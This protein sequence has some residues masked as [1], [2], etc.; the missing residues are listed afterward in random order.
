MSDFD[1]SISTNPDFFIANE[2]LEPIDCKETT[3]Y[4]TFEYVAANGFS[5][6]TS[7]SASGIPAGATVTFLPENLSTSGLVT[8]TISNLEG[9][10]Q[11]DYPITIT[12]TP[13]VGS[14]KNRN[15]LFPFYNQ[16]C[17]SVANTDY[18]TSTT[19]VEFNTIN[20]SSLKPSGYSDYT[21]IS[22]DV[23]RGS[24]YNLTVNTNTDGNFGTNTTVWIDWNQDCDFDD[25]GETYN[26]GT[27]FN[28]LDGQ[29]SN[30][31]L[32]ITIP[33]DAVL[34]NTTM[35]VTTKFNDGTSPRSCENGFD[36]EVE[37]YTLTV[38]ASKAI[39]EFGFDNFVVF[40]NPNKGQFYIKLNSSLS[41]NIVVEILA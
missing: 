14:P 21:A 3:A 41:S 6:N 8:M 24:A 31:P 22:T 34:G 13:T 5:E 26:L 11:N 4:F 32:S 37:D 17:P 28:E 20:N 25:A 16:I 10:A 35:R 12:G 7:F 15:V 33:T 40:P 18:A 36:G 30:S 1:F 19:L 29:T 23:N 2:T 27:T 39:E 38:Q 9:V